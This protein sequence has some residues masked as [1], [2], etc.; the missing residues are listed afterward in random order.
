MAKF[1]KTGLIDHV[2]KYQGSYGDMPDSVD[3]QENMNQVREA[4][5]MFLSLPSELRKD[6]NNSAFEFLA[7]CQ[8]P[9]NEEEM[10]DMGLLP[11]LPPSGEAEQPSPPSHT[12]NPPEVSQGEPNGPEGPS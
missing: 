6:F 8:N 9:E 2:N 1:A 11:S 7:F 3:L 5:E 4:E 10:R 12:E